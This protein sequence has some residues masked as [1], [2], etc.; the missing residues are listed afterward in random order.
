MKRIAVLGCT[1]SIG[2]QVLEVVQR[3]PSELRVAALAADTNHA[4]VAEQARE[5]DPGRLAMYDPAAAERL[6]QALQRPVASEMQGLVDLVSDPDVDVVVV[7]V[8]GMIGLEPTL[9]AVAAGKQIALASKEVLVAGGAVVMPRV[10]EAGIKFMPIDSEHSAILQ[11]LQETPRKYVDRVYLTASGGPFRG[12]SR[13]AMEN[14]TAEQA[15]NHPTWRMGGKITVDSATMMNKGLEIIEACWLFD[16]EPEKIE[17]IVHPQSIIHSMVKFNDGSVLAQMGHPDMK[18]PIQYALLGP[19]RLPSPTKPWEP[20]CT[21][22]LS[23]EPLDGQVFNCPDLAR[24]AFRRGGV[25]PTF[26]NAVNEEAANA[27]LRGELRF[28][29]IFR[30]N[31]ESLDAAPKAEPTL[32]NILSTDSNARVWARERFKKLSPA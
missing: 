19:E 12:W 17:V 26:L 18:L 1:G 31:E 7:S 2:R 4:Q 20:T 28:L 15:L 22:N 23:F 32:E 29:D 16:I 27:F 24:E 30:L 14:V 21:P 5:F 9:A 8:S 6:S 11:C 3:H 13:E 25:A 10:R